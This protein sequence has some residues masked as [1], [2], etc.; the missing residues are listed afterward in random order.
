MRVNRFVRVGRHPFHPGRADRRGTA[1]LRRALTFAWLLAVALVM[2]GP[3][4][5]LAQSASDRA[6]AEVEEADAAADA[7][8]EMVDEEGA[9]AEAEAVEEAADDF[10]EFDA[11]DAAAAASE[12]DDVNTDVLADQTDPAI[13]DDDAEEPIGAYQGLEELTVTAAKRKQSVQDVPISVTAIQGDFL[14]ETGTTGFAEIQKFVPN[15]QILPVTDTRSTSIRIRGIGSVGTNAG[16]DPSVG[17]FIDGVY[18]GRAGMSVNDL[19][20]I[21]RIEVLRGPQGTLYG[22]N[23]AAGA[24][25]IITRDP[26]DEYEFTG[27]TVLGNYSQ[28]EFRG[29]VNIPMIEETLAARISGYKVMRDGFDTNRFN[30]ERVNTADKWGAR[31]KLLYQPTETTDLLVNGDYSVDASKCCVADIITYQGPNSLG[32]DFND[33]ADASGIPLAKEDPYDR[34]VG[35]NVDPFNRV[36]VGGVS[37]KAAQEIGD[38]ELSWLNAWRSYTSD[39]QFDADFSIYDAVF[40]RTDVDYWQFSSELL[41]VSPGGETI[42]YQA[43]LYYYMSNLHTVDVLGWSEF[44]ADQSALLSGIGAAFNVNDNVHKTFSASGFSQMTWNFA[45]DWSLTGGF[46]LDYERKTRDGTS[47]SEP[48]D[49]KN[50]GAP[51]V[52]GPDSARNQAR[53]VWNPQGTA[54]LR[55]RPTDT[56]MAYASIANGFKSGG[57]NQ[58]RTS[59]SEGLAGAEFDDEK[60][61]NAEI[62]TKTTWI[63]GTLLFNLTG[64]FTW[65][66]DFQAQ[67]FNGSVITVDNAGSMRSSGI[68]SEV[69]WVPDF[70]IFPDRNFVLGGSLGVNITAYGDYEGAPATLPQQAEIVGTDNAVGIL[71]GFRPDGCTQDLTGERIDN[72]PRITLTLFSSYEREIPGTDLIWYSSGNYLYETFKY[73]DTDLDPN[74]IQTPIHLLGLRTGFKTPNDMI[75]VSFWVENTLNERWWVT[76]SDVPI[77]SGYFAVNAPPRT[78]GGTLRIRY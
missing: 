24:I 12:P 68:E 41:L 70:S 13:V 23:T 48:E 6:A 52:C 34:I 56:V 32:I 26:T 45:E 59:A 27:E 17:V 57:F 58:L 16:I 7:F 10:D 42:E 51:P 74:T 8:E 19:L 60:S 20:D 71:C 37:L 75:D 43:G 38:Y 65:Y 78:F 49:C 14:Q 63:D 15:L 72:A 36:T 54:I 69:R 21:E 3:L 73:L 33:L 76:S 46:R 47:I 22:K 61:L 5:A 9:E 44:Y 1:R 11:F 62:G 50:L 30:G 66:R 18:Q 64:Y 67:L 31:I 53:H 2:V 77:V 28:R 35:A 39:S 29:S 40:S 25:S 4:D 55:Y